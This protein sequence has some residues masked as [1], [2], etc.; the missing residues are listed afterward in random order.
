MTN[1]IRIIYPLSS[2]NYRLSG[3]NGGVSRGGPPPPP[4]DAT[5]KV[6]DLQTY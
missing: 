3:A 2:F 6:I 4:C 5:A 1:L